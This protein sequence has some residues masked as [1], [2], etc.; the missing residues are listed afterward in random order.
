MGEQKL[1]QLGVFL[2]LAVLLVACDTDDD[3]KA[4]DAS[5][6]TSPTAVPWRAADIPV[7]LL[8]A[9]QLELV[10]RISVHNGTVG[11][12]RFSSDS[13]FL[14]TLS[15]GDSQVN[16]WN[17]E[18]G[19]GVIGTNVF[20]PLNT[21]FSTDS[22][23]FYILNQAQQIS[24]WSM[25]D[26]TRLDTLELNLDRAGPI[27]FT[28]D[29]RLAAIGGRRGNVSLIRLDPFEQIATITAHPIVPVNIVLLSDNGELLLTMG[30]ADDITLWDVATREQIAVFEGYETP[31][32]QVAMSNDGAFFAASFA[33][34]IRI[35]STELLEEIAVLQIPTNAAELFMDFSS[36]ANRL[37]FFGQ[38]NAVEL[39]DV[40]EQTRLVQLGRHNG[41]IQQAILDTNGN[42][43]LTTTMRSVYLWDLNPVGRVDADAL[44]VLRGELPLPP[45]AQ[46]VIL[47]EWS[48]DRS[49]IALSN[50]AGDVFLFGIPSEID[51]A[52]S[53]SNPDTNGD[54]R[55]D[56]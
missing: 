10:G 37:Y 22:E 7:D 40:E 46:D 5:V 27:V 29:D 24:Q 38:G 41:N 16:V 55:E 20:A 32:Q 56:N 28:P 39:W 18:T 12:L 43:M 9:P 1:W 34:A 13:R 30:S 53:Q 51:P 19:E 52:T 21:L 54:N 48:P 45:D 47:L 8:N 44:D 11:R 36:D 4:R 31:V 3:D 17:L 23:F 14:S 26:G 35:Y 2:I 33:E 42:L 15:S 49:T 6:P 50:A 25:L